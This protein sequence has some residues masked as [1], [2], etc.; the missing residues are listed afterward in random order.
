MWEGRLSGMFI[1][2][3]TVGG[4][5]KKVKR[6]IKIEFWK[7]GPKEPERTKLCV[8]W[9]LRTARTDKPFDTGVM[10]P[11]TQ[12][13]TTRWRR[14]Y[15]ATGRSAQYKV[16][17]PARDQE[18]LS[19]RRRSGRTRDDRLAVA[20]RGESE[21]PKHSLN[22]KRINIPAHTQKRWEE[23]TSLTLPT[24]I[25]HAL[26]GHTRGSGDITAGCPQLGE[27]DPGSS[28]S[29]EPVTSN[30]KRANQGCHEGLFT[31]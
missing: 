6:E 16:A 25:L 8:R 23:T 5:S 29:D 11:R 3:I 28:A 13:W 12:G 20:G 30:A 1:L 10:T 26:A 17:R 31:L 24:S 19:S 9:F 18:G 4:Y 27:R 14:R 2:E 22:L 7:K 21:P 15:E